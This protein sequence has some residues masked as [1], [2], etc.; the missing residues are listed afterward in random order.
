[1]GHNAEGNG[2]MKKT[3]KNLSKELETLQNR[4]KALLYAN[5]GEIRRTQQLLRDAERKVEDRFG[6]LNSLQTTW[7]IAGMKFR[8]KQVGTQFASEAKSVQGPR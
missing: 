7:E 5:M 8:K 6:H 2:P 1:M 4:L 3:R